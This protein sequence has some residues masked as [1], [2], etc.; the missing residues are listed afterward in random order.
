[1]LFYIPNSCKTYKSL[2]NV[3]LL[4]DCKNVKLLVAICG[5][6]LCILL[7]KRPIPVIDHPLSGY[8]NLYFLNTSMTREI[9]VQSQVESI[10]KTQKMVLDNSQHYKVWI[11]GKVEQSRERSSALTYT[12]VS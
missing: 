5:F 10:P 12:L 2:Q 3:I 11:K 1:M 9:G 7:Y 4:E 8:C 6:S